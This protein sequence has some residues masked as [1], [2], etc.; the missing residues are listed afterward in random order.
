MQYIL[1]TDMFVQ[2]RTK[3]NLLVILMLQCFSKESLDVN[4]KT[5]QF[6]W[7]QLLSTDY[8]NYVMLKHA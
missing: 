8:M 7:N 3:T 4:D 1:N 6:F 2:D 5:E